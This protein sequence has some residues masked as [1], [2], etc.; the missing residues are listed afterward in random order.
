MKQARGVRV[1]GTG[2][3]LPKR[4]MTNAELERMV[5]T[6][7]AWIQERTGITER[8]IAAPDQAASDLALAA[9]RKALKAA[10]LSPQQ[11]G[12]ILVATATPDMPF[13]P[14]ACLVQHKLRASSA[15]AFDLGAVCS[16]F[17]YG[18]SVAAGLILSGAYDTALVIG[19]EVFSRILDWEDRNTCVLFADG[20]GA[21]V[22]QATDQPGVFASYMGCDGGL[23]DLLMVPAGGSRAPTTQDTLRQ[24]LHYLK[25]ANGKEVFRS[26]V[27]SMARSCTAVLEETGLEPADVDVL[28][29]HQ[30]NL[31]IMQALAQRLSLPEDRLVANVHKYGN[32]SAAS[33][34][35]AL[36]EA[37]RSGRIRGGHVVLMV[38]F[39]SG[40]TWGAVLLRW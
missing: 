19:A 14:T 38:A 39:G 27:Q 40:L 24:G 34:P 20:A 33:I 12:L 4:V 26:A 25:M 8:H 36:D 3:Y 15:A 21:A 17:V 5:D 10:G 32:T 37:V 18:F 29:P 30:A 16:G 28:I 6:S 1:I 2:S 9:A 23:A 7:D 22:L 11:V 31:R 13:P 35:I